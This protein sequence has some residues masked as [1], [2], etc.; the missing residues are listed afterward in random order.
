LPDAVTDEFKSKM[1]VLTSGEKNG[2]FGRKQSEE[3]RNKIRQKRIE[4]NERRRLLDEGITEKKCSKCETTKPLSE[5]NKKKDGR[6]G[7]TH[8]CKK[9]DYE[10][11]KRWKEQNREKA[12]KYAN[13][14]YHS[15]RKAA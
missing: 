9:C 7:L 8:L 14:Y 12:R 3:S 4:Y 10:Q 13:E 15:K 6:F 1:S 5:F 11:S 2:M